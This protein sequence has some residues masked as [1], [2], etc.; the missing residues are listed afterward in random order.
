MRVSVTALR[1]GL[2]LAVG[3]VAFSGAS[4]ASAGHASGGPAASAAGNRAK[5][6]LRSSQYGPMLFTGGGQAL[7]LFNRDGRNRSNCYGE[8]AVAW[9]PFKTRG[10]PIAG[11]NVIRRL[12]GTTM[13]AGGTRQVTYRG[14]PLYTYAHEGKRQVLCHDVFLNGGLWLAVKRNGRA[15]AH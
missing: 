6:T 7:Y 4:V 13:R 1:L 14:H 10:E 9:P 15:V 3:A 8:C 5:L 12:L 11:V 2:S